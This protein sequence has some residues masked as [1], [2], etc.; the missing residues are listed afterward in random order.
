MR[1]LIKKIKG[2]DVLLRKNKRLRRKIQALEIA[3]KSPNE[4]IRAV[5]GRET[6]WIDYDDLDYA[7]KKVF[8][9]SVNNLK[10]NKAFKS[11]FGYEIED[12]ERV[13][14]LI[15][16]NLI[17]SGVTESKNW[18]M[19]RDAQMSINGVE[20]IWKYL[21]DIIDPDIN[22]RDSNIERI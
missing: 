5:I 2:Y 21:D 9:Q 1:N 3:L 14:G 18:Q 7:N 15:V 10:E 12:G 13:N 16:K 22:K 17:E 11:L 20:M 6:K 19:L 4:V 8:F